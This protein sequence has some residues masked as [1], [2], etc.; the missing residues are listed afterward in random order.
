VGGG[1]GEGDQFGEG[2][3][4]DSNE[5][6]HFNSRPIHAKLR[7]PSPFLSTSSLHIDSNFPLVTTCCDPRAW[8]SRI[9]AITEVLLA[10]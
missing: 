5:A 10:C 2:G 6:L 1:A 9:H 4:N 8:V 7:C 3:A